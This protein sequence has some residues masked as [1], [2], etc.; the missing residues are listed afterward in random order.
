MT[1]QRQ[2]PAHNYIRRRGRL[3]QAQARAL[4]LAGKQYGADASQI[5]VAG[6]SPIRVGIEIGFGMGHALLDW[7]EQMPDW[8]L[9]G[10]ELYE[11]GIGAL[12]D[13][14]AK[15]K[16]TNVHIVVQPAQELFA[17]LTDH[18]VDEVRSF[19]P[20]PWPKKRHHKRR[21]IQPGF[22][23][24]LARV[25]CPGGTLRLATDWAPYAEWMREVMDHST[26]FSNLQDAVRQP[27][28]SAEDASVRST[29]KFEK[30]GEKLGHDIHDLVYVAQSKTQT[31][32]QT[33][34]CPDS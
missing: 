30:R 21:L 26:G 12:A 14:L 5:E 29:T 16:L 31:E 10:I 4:E 27:T 13:G 24:E 28:Q 1:E 11:P 8:Q 2:Y 6:K 23:D 34:H 20:D 17:E 3:T 18:L 22:V 15:R 33:P 7:A 32:K 25:M 19:F 9:F